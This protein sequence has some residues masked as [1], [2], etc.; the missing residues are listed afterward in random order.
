ML[1]MGATFKCF[2]VRK[3]IGKLGVPYNRRLR[4]RGSSHPLK[5][6]CQRYIPRCHVKQCFPYPLGL[7]VR[8]LGDCALYFL[9][10]VR[11]EARVD[12]NVSQTTLWEFWAP[13]FRFHKYFT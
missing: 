13:H 4:V 3:L 7:I 6:L 10:F 1:F 8:R 5:R 2:W 12:D 11:G 9:V